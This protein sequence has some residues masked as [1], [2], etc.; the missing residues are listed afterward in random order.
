MFGRVGHDS[1][2]AAS[3][4]IAWASARGYQS[5]QPQDRRHTRGDRG[6]RRMAA[7]IEQR[8]TRSETLLHKIAG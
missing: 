5:V 3:T 8:F 1:D 2:A 4:P 7:A 6:S